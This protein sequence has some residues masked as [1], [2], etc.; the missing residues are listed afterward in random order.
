MSLK[1]TETDLPGVLLIEPDVFK[2]S[3]GFFME[4]FH[5]EKYTEL[6]IDCDFVQ[7]NYSHSRQGAIRGLHYQL[8]HPQGKL[9]SVITGKIFDVAVDIR[10]GSPTFGQWT[11]QFLSAENRRQVFVPEGFAHGFSVLSK[12]ADV[13][14]KCTEVYKPGDEFGVLWSDSALDINWFGENPIVSDKDGQYSK[15]NEIPRHLLP[16]FHFAEKSEYVLNCNLL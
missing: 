10:Y 4:T 7:D 14:Y 6:G 12:T 8:K 2:D 3:R 5:K 13:M 9:I 16:A 1:Y 15:L 11:G